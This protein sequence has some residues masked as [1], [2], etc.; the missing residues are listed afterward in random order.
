MN[1][2]KPVTIKLNKDFRTAYYHGASQVHPALV[3]YVRRNR[4]GVTRMGI[5]TGKKIGSAV[6]RNRCRRVIREAYRALF[7]GLKAGYDIVF[8]ARAR[9]AAVKSTALT[10]VM[11]VHLRK[12]GVLPG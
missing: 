6:V 3:T 5:T 9:T 4:L 1:P 11:A 7:P 10:G 2:N 8:V 12:A